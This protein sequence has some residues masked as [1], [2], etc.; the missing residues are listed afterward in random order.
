MNA[1]RPHSFIFQGHTVT[2][3]L[4]ALNQYHF[5]HL[6]DFNPLVQTAFLYHLYSFVLD[7]Q[8]ARFPLKYL[9]HAIRLSYRFINADHIR[10]GKLTHFFY[11]ITNNIPNAVIYIHACQQIRYER[12]CFQL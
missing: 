11:Y 12:F 5:F 3:R 4:S 2:N 6:E 9:V 10:T 8:I 1:L 7:N